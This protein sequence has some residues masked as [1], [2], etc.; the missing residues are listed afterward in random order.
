MID[1]VVGAA[2]DV[3]GGVYA[4]GVIVDGQAVMIAGFS[5]IYGAHNPMR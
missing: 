1:V 5:G 3:A 2:A 4:A